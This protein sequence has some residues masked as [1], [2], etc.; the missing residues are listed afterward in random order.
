[1]KKNRK[2]K[3]KNIELLIKISSDFESESIENNLEGFIV[4]LK[5]VAKSEEE[6]PE[7]I[8]FKQ[9]DAVKIMSIHAS[10]GL[11]FEAVFLPMLWKNDYNPR[12]ASENLKYLHHSGKT[13]RYTAKNIL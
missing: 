9:S 10:K 13:G 7:S 12:S 8:Q 1:M 11:E 2:R 6:D 5:D 4:Y 3:I